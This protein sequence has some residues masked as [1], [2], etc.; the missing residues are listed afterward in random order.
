MNVFARAF[1]VMSVLVGVV[2]CISAF[3]DPDERVMFAVTGIAILAIGIAF[4]V[5]KPLRTE[6]IYSIMEGFGYRR[7]T[8]ADNSPRNGI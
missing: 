8:K 4:L 5:V 7:P 6:H 3:G 1:G 2:F